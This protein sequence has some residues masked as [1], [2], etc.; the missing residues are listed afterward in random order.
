MWVRFIVWRALGVQAT[1]AC[2]APVR[3][4]V[5]SR[6]ARRANIRYVTTN[7]AVSDYYGAV[8]FYYIKVR[9]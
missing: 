9:F 7:S 3:A 4:P 8:P 2:A 1:A 6:A 5:F